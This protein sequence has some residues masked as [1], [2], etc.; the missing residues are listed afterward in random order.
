M[1]TRPALITLATTVS[2]TGLHDK[3]RD[4]REAV[5]RTWSTTLHARWT[6]FVFVAPLD[7]EG[8]GDQGL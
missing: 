1:R 7:I 2:L 6:A 4:G 8:T 5:R 3:G